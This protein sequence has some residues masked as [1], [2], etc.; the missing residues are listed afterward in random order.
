MNARFLHSFSYLYLF[1]YSVD[2]CIAVYQLRNR[3]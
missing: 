2:N 3:L 1:T